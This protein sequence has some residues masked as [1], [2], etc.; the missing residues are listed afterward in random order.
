M[1]RSGWCANC[2]ETSHT[3]WRGGM[4]AQAFSSPRFQLAYRG[5]PSQW[6]MNCH[7]PLWREDP[8]FKDPANLIIYSDID[9]M[10]TPWSEEGINCAVCHVRD[11]KI[12]AGRQPSWWSRL[13]AT[14]EIQVDE[15]LRSPLFCGGCH[16]FN[17]PVSRGSHVRYSKVAMQN[18]VQEFARTWWAQNNKTCVNCHY[19]DGEHGTDSI[20]DPERMKQLIQVKFDMKPRGDQF[21]VQAQLSIEEIGH[22]FPTGDLFR[23]FELKIFDE[24]DNI[25]F[26][27]DI[28]KSINI[29]TLRLE[30]DT[31]LKPKAGEK[32]VTKTI[33]TTLKKKPEKCVADYALQGYIEDVIAHRLP[34]DALV[35]T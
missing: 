19:R 15:T 5:E 1:L 26:R 24:K 29:H 8:K 25:L 10:T 2:H 30:K 18:T 28:E 6:C 35:I 33:I 23:R 12:Y 9:E 34:Y 14:H 17:F 20:F 4:H 32:G 27:E 7:A 13:T 22:N 31:S 16:Q 21:E 3:D 11:G